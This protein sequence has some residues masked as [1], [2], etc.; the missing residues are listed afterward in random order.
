MKELNGAELAGYIKARQ[1]KQVRGLRQ[2]Q[3]IVPKLAI[4]QTKDDPVINNYVALKKRYAAD[5]LIE[6]E[7]FIAEQAQAAATIEQLNADA[8][9]HGIIVQLPL[10]DTSQTDELLSKVAP[11]KDVDALGSDAGFEPATPMAINWLLAGYNIELAGKKIAVVGKGK[12]VGE[13]LVKMWRNSGLEV[14]V[15]NSET[16]E[17]AFLRTLQSAQVIVSGTGVPG[18]IASSMVAPGAVVVD[19]GVATEG[20]KLV[21]DLAE[22]V[23]Q[24]GDITLTPA[25]GGVGPLTVCALFD[26]VIR[27]AR[28]SR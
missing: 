24:R 2:S 27:A 28:G 11:K 20:G 6:V 15:V 1:A 3:H 9:V 19:A 23:R 14:A 12:L 26:N 13:P 21:G 4:V 25:K 16:P 8:S 22:D 10:A 17:A 5:I 7:Q 18:L